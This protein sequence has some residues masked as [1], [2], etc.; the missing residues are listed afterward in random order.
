MSNHMTKKVLLIGAGY[1]AQEYAKVLK[2]MSVDFTVVGKGEEHAREFEKKIGLPVITGGIESYLETNQPDTYEYVINSSRVSQL[3]DVTELL[4]QYGYKH[5]L[6]EKP[7]FINRQGADKINCAKGSAVIQLAYNRRFYKSVEEAKKLIEED[8][9]VTSFNFEFTE[10][11]HIFDAREDKSELSSLI[12]INS[13]HVIDMAFFLAGSEA[14]KLDSHISGRNEISWHSTGSRYSGSGVTKAGQLF[15]YHADFDAPGRWRVEVNTRKH[16]LIFCPLEKLQLQDKGSVNI[17]LPQ[18]DYS[19]D[20]AFKPGV[21][22]E[23]ETFLQ[24]DP[25]GKLC[26]FE[27]QYSRLNIIQQL[28]GEVY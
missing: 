6:S 26:T 27:E 12:L 28:S 10:W 13:T 17:Y 8:G 2:D 22:R 7:G 20:E 16:R 15:S 18:I 24:D 21:Y 3:A 4:L 19:I 9:G 1:M 11:R 23:V 25:C 14:E 5:I